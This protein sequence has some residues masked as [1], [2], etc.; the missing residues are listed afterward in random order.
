[1]S[2]S[3][4]DRHGPPQSLKNGAFDGRRRS[5]QIAGPAAPRRGLRCK[6]FVFLFHRPQIAV[7]PV[8]CFLDHLVSGNVVAGIVNHAALVLGRRT[9]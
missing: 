8:E 4:D 3:L 6:A 9:Q 2:Y 7:Q 5:A 1:M